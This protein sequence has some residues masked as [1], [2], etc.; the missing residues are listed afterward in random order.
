MGCV[1]RRDP[2]L[3]V[4]V[5]RGGGVPHRDPCRCVYVHKGCVER[6][7]LHHRD[8]CRCVNVERGGV[9]ITEILVSVYT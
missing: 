4:H 7:C 5:E 6:V 3:S 9:F 2:C 8:P 1:H